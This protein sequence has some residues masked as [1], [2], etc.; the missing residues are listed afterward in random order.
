MVRFYGHVVFS[1]NFVYAFQD[2]KT[3]ANTV[4]AHLFQFRMLQRNERITVHILLCKWSAISQWC[5][6]NKYT[7]RNVLA[8]CPS[9]RL[10]IQS[11][12]CSGVQLVMMPLGLA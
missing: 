2:C 4:Y 10:D 3:V 11:A 6:T 12:T 5:L 7:P 9:P 1:L 8:Y